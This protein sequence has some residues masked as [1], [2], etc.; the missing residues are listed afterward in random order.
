MISHQ[1]Q[2]MYLQKRGCK[3]PKGW[4]SC[5]TWRVCCLDIKIRHVY[6]KLWRPIKWAEKKHS[7]Y[8]P[9]RFSFE[10]STGQCNLF[11]TQDQRARLP[12]MIRRM[13]FF[14]VHERTIYLF[15]WTSLFYFPAQLEGGSTLSDFLGKS[16]PQVPIPSPRPPDT[17]LHCYRAEGSSGISLA[18]RLCIEFCQLALSHFRHVSNEQKKNVACGNRTHE[19]DL[20]RSSYE[21]N[22]RP[23]GTPTAYDIQS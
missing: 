20:T 21:L 23:P 6:T 4:L 16:W 9:D 3:V 1:V 22:T 5:T 11:R 7:N 8:Q 18:R 14:I 12:C 13:V 19:I 2:V 10:L 15:F 17:Y